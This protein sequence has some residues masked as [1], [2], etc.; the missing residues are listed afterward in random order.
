M[1]RPTVYTPVENYDET[2]ILSSTLTSTSTN[3]NG[4]FSSSD[5][6]SWEEDHRP[7]LPHRASSQY[8]QDQPNDANTHIP[9][10]TPFSCA[11]NLSNT[12]LGTGMLAM[13]SAMA[14]VGLLPGILVILIS[15]M[16]SGSGLYFLTCC[17]RRT[18]GR[19]ASFFAISKLT[20]PKMAV[21]VASFFNNAEHVAILMDRRFWITLFMVTAV[22]PLSFLRKL[23]SLKYT[24]VVALI[25]VVYLCVIVVEHYF[26]GDF[27]P[28]PQGSVELITFSSKF[29]SHLPVFVFAFT[30]HQN[31]FSVYNELEDNSQRVINK[32][33]GIAIGSSTFMYELIAIL[34]YL[35]FGKNVS[36]NV[37]SEYHQSLFVACGRLAI[38]ILVVFS[39]PLQAHP[40]RA[41]LDKVLAW[42][43]PNTRGLKVPPLPSPF[44]YFAMTTTILICSYLVAITVTK[45]DLVLAFVGSTGST[46]VSF[47]LP[48]FFYFKIHENDPWEYKKIASLGLAIYGLLVMVICLA[49]NIIHLIH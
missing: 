12:I 15:A 16:A 34:G 24:S 6:T 35:S 5:A 31:I 44:K 17:A 28:P 21:V 4:A 41:S 37:I 32:T 2:S 11:I 8:C 25:A 49:F 22:L 30:C 23:D 27:T 36:G 1:T 13:P 19:N 9:T 7:L 48:G 18:E 26:A 43:S 3:N 14:S 33:I 42:N 45:L 10:A 29:F 47:I 38:V 20:W 39:Y 46:T 40:C